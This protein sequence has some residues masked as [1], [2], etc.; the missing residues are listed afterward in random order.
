MVKRIQRCAATEVD[1]DAGV[2]DLTIPRSLL[3]NLGHGDFG[4]YAEV[5]AGG[6][7]APGDAII[8]S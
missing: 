1:P 3:Q 7:I 2:R 5:A 4:V 6:E 8:T